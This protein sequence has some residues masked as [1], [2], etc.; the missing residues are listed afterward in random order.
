MKT[1]AEFAADSAAALAAL[2]AVRAQFPEWLEAER[3]RCGT[4]GWPHWPLIPFQ[5]GEKE[6]W[7]SLFRE[8]EAGARVRAL[9]FELTRK[10]ERRVVYFYTRSSPVLSWEAALEKALEQCS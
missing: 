7:F 6:W 1:I 9:E 5:V 3:L 2:E 4:E 10:Q 8:K